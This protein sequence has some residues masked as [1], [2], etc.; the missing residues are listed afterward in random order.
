MANPITRRHALATLTAGMVA[1]PLLATAAEETGVPDGAL[2][3]V[4]CDPLAAP[5]SCPCVKGYAQRDYD[6]LGKFL[7][8]KLGRPVKVV[9]AETLAA[10]L[11]KKTGGRADVVIGKDSV[12]RA[13]AK[14]N[15]LGMTHLAALTGKDG[16]TTQTGLVVVASADPA[17]TAD[18][19]KDYRIL[20][21]PAD[22]DE[23][24][25]AALVLLKDLNVAVP[26]VPETCVA[27][28]EGATKILALHKQGV[29]AAAV[30]S[31]YA[32]PLLEGCGTIKKG[33]LRVVGQTDPVPFVAAF[34]TDR[35]SAGDGAAIRAALLEIGHMPELCSALETKAGFV[36]PPAYTSKKK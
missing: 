14:A 7:E 24:H 25:A 2:I 22:S 19:L 8:G 4:V 9:F 18:A 20:F 10:A 5:L 29:K 21:G 13:A 23:K 30:I 1:T 17:L 33:D 32:Q 36:D 28:T 3:V 16:T 31:S 26:V 11:Q 6:K 27:C 35:V 34:V 12:V 15:K